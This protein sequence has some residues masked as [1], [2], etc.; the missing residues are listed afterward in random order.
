MA[1]NQLK[2]KAIRVFLLYL[3]VT[4]VIYRN[5][6]TN[7]IK[8][9]IYSKNESQMATESSIISKV[10]FV[11]FYVPLW[12]INWTLQMIFRALFNFVLIIGLFYGHYWLHA[13]KKKAK[14]QHYTGAFE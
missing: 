3:V 5:F 8:I 13:R 9:S 7:S 1:H 11:K 4:R 10:S 2:I 12:I 6:I 14:Q